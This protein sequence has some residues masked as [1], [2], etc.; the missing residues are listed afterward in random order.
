VQSVNEFVFGD[1]LGDAVGDVLEEL[2]VLR[3]GCANY[4]TEYNEEGT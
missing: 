3:I 4:V 1:K 2:E